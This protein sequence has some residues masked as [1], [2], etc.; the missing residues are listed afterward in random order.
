MAS[1]LLRTALPLAAAPMAGG[2]STVGLARSVAAAGA[3]P[4]LAAGYQTPERLAGEIDA[5][6]SF[7][8]EFGVNVFV[9]GPSVHDADAL[10]RFA[11]A[12]QPV[13]EQFGVAIPTAPIQHDRDHWEEKLDQLIHD[14]V[15]V[16]SFTFSLPAA[17]EVAALRNAGT[18]TLATVTSVAEA[19]AAHAI[20]VDGLVVQGWAAGGHS[21]THDPSREIAA[22]AT[23]DL[24]R[25]I[26]AAIDLPVSAAGGVDGPEAVQRL[27]LAGAETVTVGTLLLRADESGASA[28]HKNAL[29]DRRFTTT[30]ISAAYTGRPARGLRNRF[31]EQFDDLATI[32][33][34]A[35]HHLTRQIRQAAANAGDPEWLH[36][37]AGTGYRA[38]STGPAARI[39][40]RLAARL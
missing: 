38:A 17:R 40:A 31:M 1:P 5:V 15:P 39:L 27:L 14:P 8:D 2:P 19:K 34:P 6:R 25:A 9:P 13:A 30:A 32:G 4:S 18:R 36:L 11:Q 22:V 29:A 12:L 33:Y 23:E 16:V 37:W 3:F 20:G 28:A 7:T 26:R 21:A 35:V 10:R 24:V